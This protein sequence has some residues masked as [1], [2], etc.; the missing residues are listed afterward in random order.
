MEEFELEEAE[1]LETACWNRL[2][3]MLRGI[4]F[5][6]VLS[7]SFRKKSSR[8]I[9]LQRVLLDPTPSIITEMLAASATTESTPLDILHSYGKNQGSETRNI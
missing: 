1:R 8:F 9:C 7:S 6:P 2:F 3:W 5:L 4:Y